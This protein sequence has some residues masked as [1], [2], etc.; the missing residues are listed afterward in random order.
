[1]RDHINLD[2]NESNALLACLMK[3]AEVGHSIGNLDLAAMALYLVDLIIDKWN[4]EGDR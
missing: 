1:M 2:N 3:A 4:P